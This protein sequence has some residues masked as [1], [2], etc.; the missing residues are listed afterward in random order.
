MIP[1]GSQRGGGQQLA[2]HLL[3]EFDN[4][5]VE[6]AHVRGSI[7]NDLHGAFAEWR[8][9]SR[10]TQCRKYLYSLSLNPDPKQGPLT[11]TQ[12][13]DF[14]NRAEQRLG[15]TGQPRA[16]VFHVK[17]G[18]EHCHVVWSRIDEKAMKAVQISHDHQNLR[19]VARA[20]AREHGLRL[21]PAMEKNRGSDRFLDRQKRENLFEQQ[22]QERSGITKAQRVAAITAA[23][24]QTRD[25]R[26]FV[27]A[28]RKRGYLLARGDARTYVVVDRAGEIHALAR[29]IDGARTRQVRERLAAYPLERLPDAHSAQ[30]LLRKAQQ[31]GQ[32]ASR[33]DQQALS[34]QQ[35]R[36][37]L[38]SRQEQRRAALSTQREALE[39]HHATERD[40]LGKEQALE[41]RGIAR[42]R[43]KPGPVMGFLM[44][45]TGLGRLVDGRRQ[46]QDKARRQE[47][48]QQRD[49]LERRHHREIVDFRHREHALDSV[50]AR[51]RRSLETQIRRQ[52]FVRASA[53]EQGMARDERP[54]P[55]AP[56]RARPPPGAIDRVGEST[57][58]RLSVTWEAL[59]L[60]S[61]RARLLRLFHR[62]TAAPAADPPL[63]ARFNPLAGLL[64]TPVPPAPARSFLARLFG[65][66]AKPETGPEAPREQAAP[67]LA[68]DRDSA[69]SLR[70]PFNRHAAGSEP[71]VTEEPI[72]C[73]LSGLSRA[74]TEAAGETAESAAAS[75]RQ[76]LLDDFLRSASPPRVSRP[77]RQGTH[78]PRPAPPPSGMTP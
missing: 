43:A 74:F 33:E 18:R 29:Q 17:Y 38:E 46:R 41:E 22:Q 7:A 12:Y 57:P 23:W 52:S 73:D 4:E 67:T 75:A 44:R 63:R 2:T 42:A 54:P 49:R 62:A 21:P 55:S 5:R 40:L 48:A 69:Q 24:K 1:K 13:L 6:L 70:V 15:L 72:A 77:R 50:D 26:E 27:A 53:R 37:A 28:L 16:V 36:S 45:I 78:G 32:P 56:P 3:N 31:R 60:R 19:T 11:R 71:G 14:I 9:V 34:P 59:M 68:P 35:R 76:E 61:L 66:A 20:F 8:A 39:A 64:P 51:E 30:A 65:A 47:H 58:P 25:A 10:A